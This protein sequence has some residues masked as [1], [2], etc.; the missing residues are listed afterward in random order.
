MSRREKIKSESDFT[1]LILVAISTPFHQLFTHKHKKKGQCFATPALCY[2]LLDAGKTGFQRHD[3][4]LYAVRSS[5]P[6][7]EKKT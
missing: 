2:C 3:R 6:L 7:D 5:D 4:D 1:R